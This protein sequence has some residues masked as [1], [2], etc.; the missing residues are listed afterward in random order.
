[1]LS[2]L[3]VVQVVLLLGIVEWKVGLKGSLWLQAAALVLC[4]TAGTG[5]GLLISALSRRQERAVAAVPLLI[6]PQILFSEFAIPREHFGKLTAAVENLMIVRWCYRVFVEAAKAEP[7]YMA[8][9]LSLIILVLMAVA[10]HAL[11]TAALAASR[12]EDFL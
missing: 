6:L 3:N 7:A 11:S 1:V 9:A 12:G 4:A 5:L 10:L 2:A 8:I